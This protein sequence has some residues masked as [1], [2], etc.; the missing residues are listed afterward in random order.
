MIFEKLYLLEM[1]AVSVILIAGYIATLWHTLTGSKFKLVLS[2]VTLLLINNIALLVSNLTYY[3][4]IMR[5]LTFG[6][7][8]TYFLMQCIYDI[9]FSVQHLN[10]AMKYSHITKAMPLAIEG[11][12]FTDEMKR[13]EDRLYWSLLAPNVIFPILY[14][15]FRALYTTKTAVDLM[16]GLS[17]VSCFGIFICQITSGVFLAK[18]V[19][20]INYFLRHKNPDNI[21]TK[22]LIIHASAFGIYLVSS[23]ILTFAFTLNIVYPSESNYNLWF[24]ASV[25]YNAAS[26]ISQI[27]LILIFWDLGKKAAPKKPRN[28]DLQQPFAEDPNDDPQVEEW[29]EEDEV[30]ARIWNKFVRNAA[31]SASSVQVSAASVALS[32]QPI[33]TLAPAITNI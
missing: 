18:S 7:V 3:R 22:G 32:R 26:L 10:L 5:G 2:Q 14:Y 19:I 12:P 6:W 21:D 17:I 30:Q 24:Y 20:S 31:A 4:I 9:T 11:K 25:L 15:S 29:N 13:K 27:C 16:N 1:F 8:L 23:L 28:R 33:V